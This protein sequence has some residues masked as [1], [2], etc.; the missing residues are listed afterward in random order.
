M[1]QLYRLRID[2]SCLEQGVRFVGFTE[3]KII[4]DTQITQIGEELSSFFNERDSNYD[5]QSHLALDFAGVDF[6]SNVTLGKLITA[7]RAHFEL[8]KNRLGMVNI[9]PAIY[10]VFVFTKLT[11]LFN[12]AETREAYLAEFCA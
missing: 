6:L 10:E 3:K 12:I 8:Y 5:P 1:T 11:S 9:K 7:D 2:E 4:E